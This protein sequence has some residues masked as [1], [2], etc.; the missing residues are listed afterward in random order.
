[1]KRS[2]AAEVLPAIGA[3]FEGGFLAGR[4]RIDG[5]LY[6]IIL[7]PKAESELPSAAPWNA[8]PKRVAS[9]LSFFDGLANTQAMA[10]AGSK[11]A[12]WAL[13]QKLHIPARDELE[14]LYRAFKPG[15]AA[16]YAYSGDNPSSEPV[17]YAYNPKSPAQTTSKPHRA[18]GTEALAETWY[19]SSSQYAG[20]VEYA[21]CQHFDY[22][23]QAITSLKDN[24]LRVRAVRRF[25]I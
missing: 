6:A 17:G 21:W 24:E 22:G 18:G 4:I 12:T 9:A 11:I 10:K 1:M 19:W 23:V 14:L 8:T 20:S 13:D 25:K 7:P 2:T 16:S 3:A 15:K 5:T